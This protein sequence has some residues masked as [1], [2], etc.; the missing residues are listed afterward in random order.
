MKHYSCRN[1][2]SI[3][4][5][6]TRKYLNKKQAKW[7]TVDAVE[8]STAQFLSGAHQNYAAGTSTESIPNNIQTVSMELERETK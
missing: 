8:V 4:K 6:N 1:T 2:V 5:I 3:I 7:F